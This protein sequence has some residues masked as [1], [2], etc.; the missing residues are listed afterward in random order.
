M[1]TAHL[2]W[3]AAG[4]ALLIAFMDSASL[5]FAGRGN[6]YI[7]KATRARIL[8]AVG[9]VGSAAAAV[10]AHR[11]TRGIDPLASSGPALVWA[12][13]LVAAA[14][15][16]LSIWSKIRLGRLFTGH[17]GVKVDHTLITDGPYAIVRHPM[18]LGIILF[19][20]GSGL[21]WKSLAIALLG[22]A[23]LVCFAVQLRVEEGIFAGHFGAAYEEYRRRV[24]A[25]LP[26]PRPRRKGA[27]PLQAG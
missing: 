21:S 3:A 22:P 18:Y 8:L 2:V 19:A 16:G 4:I 15:A 5:T 26:W 14:G 17:L 10:V 12:G 24:P 25:L 11:L 9:E 7:T 27:T 13:T 20:I 1:N 23:W 6:R